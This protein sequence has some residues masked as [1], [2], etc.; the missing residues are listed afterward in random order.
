MPDH[1]ILP[2]REGDPRKRQG[3]MPSGMWTDN[4]AQVQGV[5]DPST[6][7]NWELSP[8]NMPQAPGAT[9]QGFFSKLFQNFDKGQAKD[10]FD[11]SIGDMIGLANFGANNREINEMPITQPMSFV[12]PVQ[13]DTTRRDAA[14]INEIRRQA[15]Q[16]SLGTT[17]GS[18]QREGN[19]RAVASAGA[20]GATNQ[21]RTAENLRLDS[22]RARNAQRGQQSNMINAGIYNQQ[23]GDI[24]QNLFTQS[25]A[26]VA[27]RQNL[28]DTVLGNKF[29]RANQDLERE[30]M[31]LIAM[32]DN[33]RGTLRRIYAEAMSD[34]DKF[35]PDFINMLKAHLGLDV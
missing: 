9:K 29:Q 33:D 2:K 5:T 6:I 32:R 34:P 23:M 11:R 17:S 28:V 10:M 1:D 27:N 21:A 16:A 30:R 24:N 8:I 15:R 20:L 14:A 13:E 25:Q 12:E 31:G 4:T 18:A 26:R 35:G 7:G 3:N 19:I 22:V